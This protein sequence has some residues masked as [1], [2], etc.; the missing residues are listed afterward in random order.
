MDFTLLQRGRALLDFEV[1]ARKSVTR[2]HQ[3][4]E[5]QLA[6]VGL[7]AD[8]LPDDMEARHHV[9]DAALAESPVFQAR[10]L[11]GEWCAKQHGRAA[12]QAF[13][14]IAHDLE[15][16]L[17]RLAE[18]GTTIVEHEFT[19]P[20]YWSEIW[21]HR[22]HGGWDA[23]PYNGFVHGELVHK[24]YVSQVFPGDIYGNRRLVLRELPR[25]D[26]RDILE[27][28]T[29]SGHH[30][31]AI[32]EIFPDAAIT[33][34]DPSIR[35]LEQARRVANE[36]GLG[37]NLHTGIGEDMPM[38]ADASFDLVTAY[39]IHHE[40]PPKAIAA[41]FRE[42][43]RVL[44]PGGDMIMADVVRTGDLDKMAAW[45]MDYAAKWGGEPFWRATAALDMEPMAREAGFV[46]VR[47]YAPQPG[48][49]PYVIYGRKPA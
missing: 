33:G 6:T 48:R 1:T 26:Y 17:A 8:T 42:A 28:G 45:R 10:A 38:F 43:F 29:S 25:Q 41:T 47:G 20:R 4:A 30:T 13:D 7:T 12:Q 16:E 19:A 21:F 2:L 35:M 39:A 18:G 9:I 3:Q 37:W 22:T 34:I 32:A 31:V 11:L 44:R 46:D 14:E 27:V 49:D 23:G 24:K 15:P 36:K 5:A 40:M